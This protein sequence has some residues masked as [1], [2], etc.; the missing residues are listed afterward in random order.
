MSIFLESGT[1]S[2]LGRL[3]KWCLFPRGSTRSAEGLRHPCTRGQTEVEAQLH[4]FST[5]LDAVNHFLEIRRSSCTK[6]DSE[7]L[8]NCAVPQHDLI[9]SAKISECCKTSRRRL[10]NVFQHLRLQL[11]SDFVTHTSCHQGRN[12]HPFE[13]EQTLFLV[14]LYLAVF[15][16]ELA[17]KE[18]CTSVCTK[19]TPVL[20][21]SE[22]NKETESV[23]EL[24]TRGKALELFILQEVCMS[25]GVL[26]HVGV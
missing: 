8:S 18:Q 12:Q 16:L 13:K 1:P 6:A 19:I 20:L 21:L 11:L 7:S 24:H 10:L 17:K 3:H 22:T 4:Q 23:S 25:P 15:R 2:S 14:Q 26:R 9:G 5:V